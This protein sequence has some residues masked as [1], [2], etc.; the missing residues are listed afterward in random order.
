MKA[1]IT[2]VLL[3]S[4][5]IGLSQV[6]NIGA[7]Q[8]PG[9]SINDT[10]Y[11]ITEVWIQVYSEEINQRSELI[12]NERKIEALKDILHK[13]RKIEPVI[14]SLIIELGNVSKERDSIVNVLKTGLVDVS[15][16][17]VETIETYEKKIFSLSNEVRFLTEEKRKYKN[18]LRLCYLIIGCELILIAL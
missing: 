2:V 16:S 10:I 1:L 11:T 3:L 15:K 13:K 6:K 9:Y 12:N 14:D 18:R 17:M 5:Q 4:C 7:K 8:L